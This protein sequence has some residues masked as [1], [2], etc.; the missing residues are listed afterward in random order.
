M[1]SVLHKWLKAMLLLSL[2][3]AV[4]GKAVAIELPWMLPQNSA[5]VPGTDSTASALT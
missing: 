5:W 3:S 1:R 4:L 2:G